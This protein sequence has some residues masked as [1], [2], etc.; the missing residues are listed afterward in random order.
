MYMKAS[1]FF[2]IVVSG[3]TL[4]L[5]CKKGEGKTPVSP[6]DTITTIKYIDTLPPSTAMKHTGGLQTQADF[7]RIK[8]KVNAQAE[9]WYS[10]WNK[11]IANSHAQLSYT[12]GPT[13]LLI[14]GGSSAEQPL[15]DN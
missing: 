9:P 8:T 13:A 1:L 10:G 5:S 6:V 15:P 11:L 4:V 12:A 14:R 2:L 3:S 7:D